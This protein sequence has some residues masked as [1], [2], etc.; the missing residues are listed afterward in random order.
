MGRVGKALRNLD[1]LS[2]EKP[3]AIQIQF[4]L[5]LVC[6]KKSKV[7]SVVPKQVQM[8]YIR[9]WNY[10][11]PHQKVF[12]QWRQDK[13]WTTHSAV[14]HQKKIKFKKETTGIEVELI[15]IAENHN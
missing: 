6:I 7:I 9:L 4:M 11:L 5:F 12:L 1:K 2:R 13:V 10:V 8:S 15:S 3:E 14:V